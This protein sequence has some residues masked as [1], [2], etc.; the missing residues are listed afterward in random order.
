MKKI[1]LL[2]ML[3]TSIA[4]ELCAQS[5]Q[6]T[7][8][9]FEVPPEIVIHRRFY[10]QLD[11]GNKLKLEITDI[12]DLDML[13]NID[14]L[15]QV[16]INDISGLKDSLAD[17][18]KAKRIDYVTDAAGRKKIRLQQYP[19]QGSTFLLNQQGAL[20]SLRI[21]QDTIH[22][23]GVLVNPPPANEKISRTHPRYYHLT[24]YLNN[25]NELAGYMG[26]PLTAKINTI[27]NNVNSRWPTLLGTGSH[28]LKKDKSIV[29][30]APR[31]FTGSEADY[32]VG[33]ATINVQNY[34]NYFVP[35]FSIGANLILSNR[36]RTFKREIGLQWEPHFFFARNNQDKLQTYRNDFLNLSFGQGGITDHDSRKDFSFK[37]VFS[38]GYVIY[39]QGDFVDKNTF[40]FGAGKIKFYK[41]T[42]EPSVYF[43]NLFR[44]VTPGIRITQSF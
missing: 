22:I 38:L 7:E 18:V 31:G 21:E 29:A 1:L 24:F 17:P 34:K 32:I 19:P 6:K 39:R 30:D 33:F 12:R 3:F 26:G 13:Q 44:G 37:A 10:I 5:K 14:S 8:Q 15:L 28:F 40:R 9:A 43:N 23:I 4:A 11:D 25:I 41:T 16:F 2:L 27:R 35:S 20:A 42:I 36:D